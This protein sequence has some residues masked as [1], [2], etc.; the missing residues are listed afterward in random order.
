MAADSTS[1]CRATTRCTTH[2]FRTRY[3]AITVPRLIE[4]FEQS[5]FEGV[6]RIDGPYF[7][8]VIVGQK[9]E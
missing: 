2:T 4:L 9:P 3:Y 1:S 5:G 8:P 6:K 7:Q